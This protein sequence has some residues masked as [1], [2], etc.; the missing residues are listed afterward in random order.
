LIHRLVAA[1]AEGDLDSEEEIR[2]LSE[3]LIAIA[4][5]SP[6]FERVT[7]R[8]VALLRESL[9]GAAEP[10]RLEVARVLGRVGRREDAPTA[11]FLLKDPSAAVRRA[12]VEALARLEPGGASEPLRL[13]LAD[14]APSVRIAAV[15]TLAASDDDDVLED[16]QPALGDADAQVRAAAV[17]SIGTRFGAS[18][19]AAHRE[20]AL[21]ILD[22]ALTDDA[23]VAMGAVEALAALGG[24]VADRAVRALS[25]AEPELVKE[26][27]TCL[28]R[29]AAPATLE[30]IIPL[31]SHPDWS[32]RA[33]VIE[34]LA[35]RGIVR[36]APEI[37]RRLE[38][39]RDEFVR[40]V[41][42]RATASLEV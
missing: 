19:K 18:E 25:R 17:R 34:S 11:S 36:A 10:V 30:R 32:V 41:I 7:D 35:E 3:T 1:A 39:E 29:H 9:E 22:R 4:E 21:E 23:L 5:R 12:A 2:A 20:V 33:E 13:A 31:V 15:L 6:G 40:E 16:L 42:L 38:D 14:E 26:A 37:L 27:V 8:A 24:A 28:A